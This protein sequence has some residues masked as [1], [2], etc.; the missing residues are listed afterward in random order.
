[1]LQ[2]LT[3]LQE[4]ER[5]R[6]EFL[7]NGEPRAA[8]TADLHQGPIAAL[9]NEASRRSAPPPHHRRTGGPYAGLAGMILVGDTRPDTMGLSYWILDT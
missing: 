1:M 5:L 6:A 3:T 2:N 9:M 7:G 4:M 8:H